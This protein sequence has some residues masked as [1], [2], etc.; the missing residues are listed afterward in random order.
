M[1]A[2]C[3]YQNKNP[4][5]YWGAPTV[6]PISKGQRPTSGRKKKAI[7]QRECSPIHTMVTLLYQI[8]E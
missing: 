4:S 8:L 5:Y 6:R 2:T 7:S 3:V 1:N